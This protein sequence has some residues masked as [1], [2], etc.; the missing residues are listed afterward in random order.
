MT[1][2]KKRSVNFA[3]AEQIVN[4]ARQALGAYRKTEEAKR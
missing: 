4:R 1:K 2:P 3:Q